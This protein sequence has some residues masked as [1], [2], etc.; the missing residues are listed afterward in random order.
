MPRSV[1]IQMSS[2]IFI[3]GDLW[4][5]PDGGGREG[6]WPP[7]LVGG[8]TPSQKRDRDLRGLERTGE[9]MPGMRAPIIILVNP[10]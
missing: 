4:E 7:H 3:Q 6:G 1:R 5:L 10:R 8:L 2:Y 9:E